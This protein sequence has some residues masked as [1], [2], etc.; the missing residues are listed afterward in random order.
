VPKGRVLVLGV[1]GEVAGF[2]N[3]GVADITTGMFMRL[4]CGLLVDIYL[5]A[6]YR[7]RGFGRQLVERLALWFRSQGVNHFEWHVSARN[8]A[9]L[10]FWRS[11]GAETTMLRMRATIR[12]E[13]A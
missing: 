9:A 12:E 4:R 3:G 2:I 6:A 1:E 10:A 13:T 7:R 5:R 8:Q 11:I